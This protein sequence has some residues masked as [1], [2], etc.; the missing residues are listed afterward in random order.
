LAD[1]VDLRAIGFTSEVWEGASKNQILEGRNAFDIWHRKSA[2]Q[3]EIE[4]HALYVFDFEVAFPEGG[5]INA[6]AE[7]CA[8][9]DPGPNASQALDREPQSVFI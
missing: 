5:R 1:A 7:N 2:S 4:M 6:I 9:A 8:V 3:R